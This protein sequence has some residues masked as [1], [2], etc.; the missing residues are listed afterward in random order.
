MEWESFLTGES[1]KGRVQ[2][3][4]YWKLLAW[5]SWEPANKKLE[6]LCNWFGKHI[7]FLLVGPEL[8]VGQK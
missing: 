3:C 2:V 1:K 5:R 4:S 6:I 7:C 8:K